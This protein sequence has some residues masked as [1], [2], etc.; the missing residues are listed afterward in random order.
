MR[1]LSMFSAVIFMASNATAET[2]IICE[3]N[4][5]RPSTFIVRFGD[6]GAPN[7]SNMHS[8][9]T[10]ATAYEWDAMVE[11]HFDNTDSGYE[12]GVT[13]FVD[14]ATG[15]GS[16]RFY[17]RWADNMSKKEYTSHVEVTCR[18]GDVTPKL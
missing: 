2:A 11:N 5:L 1:F 15:V 7:I 13:V 4:Q 17:V 3:S 10:S 8:Y 16:F 18:K 14:R 9:K 12:K 6:N